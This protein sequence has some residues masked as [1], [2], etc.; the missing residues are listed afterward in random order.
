MQVPFALVAAF[1]FLCS[2]ANAQSDKPCGDLAY[3]NGNCYDFV[4]RRMSWEKANSTC[5]D[6]KSHLVSIRDG[7]TNAYLQGMFVNYEI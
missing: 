1:G 3:Y 4:Y 7:A 2:V 6:R 5:A